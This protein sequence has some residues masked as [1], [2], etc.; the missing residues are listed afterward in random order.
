MA[1][2][3]FDLSDD[4]QNHGQGLKT[5]GEVAE[6]VQ[7]TPRA[8]RYYEE[9][10]LLTPVVRV[11]GVA[12]LFNESDIQRLREIKRLREI[13]G[14]SLA[15]LSELLD[16]EKVRAQLRDRFRH[17]ADPEERVSVLRQAIELAQRRLAIIERRLEQLQSVRQAELEHIELIRS[18]LREQ[19]EPEAGQRIGGGQ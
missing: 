16:N 6:L 14:F 2:E 9:L 18:L 4:A 11:K 1:T 17:T 8:I 10:G 3:D 19:G 15:E 12:R 5:I 7:L 13:A